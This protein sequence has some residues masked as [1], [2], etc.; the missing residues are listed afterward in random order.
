[1]GILNLTRALGSLQFDRSCPG[2][3]STHVLHARGTSP[4]GQFLSDQALNDAWEAAGGTGAT[5]PW[6]LLG[7]RDT[8]TGTLWHIAFTP[9]LPETDLSKV[10]GLQVLPDCLWIHQLQGEKATS[11]WSLIETTTTQATWMGLWEGDRCVRLARLP[12]GHG[13][14]AELAWQLRRWPESFGAP[15]IAVPWVSPTRQQSLKL[16]EGNPQAELLSDAE[17]AARR[18]ENDRRRSH[19]G[20]LVAASVIAVITLALWSA[21]VFTQRGLASMQERTRSL[22]PDMKRL[23][24]LNQERD[25]GLER[26]TAIPE[27]LSRNPSS[28]RWLGQILSA[29]D[30]AR[31][32]GMRL[33]NADSSSASVQ[34]DLEV[35]QWSQLNPL[36]E[37]LQK[38]PG[39]RSARYE[40]QS[41]QEDRV[42]AR[43]VLEGAT[44]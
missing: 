28:S 20:L 29:S 12:A 42:R 4:F 24:R 22:E 27:L 9:G 25:Q 1:M 5:S 40:Q 2:F 23:Q 10:R 21:K 44:P 13:R 37:R 17:S 35:D 43:I 30:G 3:A 8:P 38:V 7:S 36:L 6:F 18:E 16:L 26:L 33:E 32:E 19:R 11:G 15:R 34:L 14:D 39:I 41:R 31:L